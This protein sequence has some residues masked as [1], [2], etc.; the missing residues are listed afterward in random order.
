MIRGR[1]LSLSGEYLIYRDTWVMQY[2]GKA[3]LWTLK[4]KLL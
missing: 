4:T 1:L 3:N 2:R